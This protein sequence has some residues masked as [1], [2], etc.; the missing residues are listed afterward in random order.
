VAV[1]NSEKAFESLVLPHL[2]AA[3][4]LASWLAKN[5]HD[6]D[7]VVQESCLRALRYIDAATHE[8]CR[9]WLLSIVRN[10]FYTW[11]KKE[12]ALRS[13][14]P[15]DDEL[16]Q[17]GSDEANPEAL[18]LRDIEIESLRAEIEELPAEYR[19]V[20]VLRELEEMSYADIGQ[21]AGIPIG[22]VMSRLA[23]AR[24]RLQERLLRQK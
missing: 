16:K 22:P 6:A 15:L 18:V 10:T 23:R 12:T 8:N 9:A 2:D 14:V 20:I 13:P 7:D 11:L 1:R 19:E 4:N 24:T 17:H 5:E 21:I 3:Y